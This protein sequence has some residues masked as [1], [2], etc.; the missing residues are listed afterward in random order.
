[1][2]FGLDQNMLSGKCHDP[3]QRLRLMVSLPQGMGRPGLGGKVLPLI[4]SGTLLGYVHLEAQ[5][6]QLFM[7]LGKLQHELLQLQLS[8]LNL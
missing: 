6:A 5:H 1:M 4:C 7:C 2:D 8:V 3:H